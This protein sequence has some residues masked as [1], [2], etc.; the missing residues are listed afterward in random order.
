[1]DS[2]S[3]SLIGMG[4]AAVGM[5]GSGI[6]IGYIFGKMIEAVARQPEAEPILS[7]YAWIGFALVEA[8]A[9]YALVLA[10][11]IMGQA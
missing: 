11:I 8:I 3:A 2:Q 10:F 5:A 9:L 1:M 4:L 6:G 7:K